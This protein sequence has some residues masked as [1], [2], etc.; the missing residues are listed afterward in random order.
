MSAMSTRVVMFSIVAALAGCSPRS[1]PPPPATAARASELP[2]GAVIPD[3]PVVLQDGFKL[4]LR[5]LK[6]KVIALYFCSAVADP[7]CVRESQALGERYRE[8]HDEHHVAIVG[9]TRENAALHRSFIAQHALP[10]DLAS[11][12]NAEVARAYGVPSQGSYAPQLFL[13]NRDNTL[14]ARWSAADPEAQLRE[15][16]AAAGG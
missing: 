9:V 14:R 10:F 11:D 6:G 15:I 5:A 7:E 4:D 3:V 12:P 8:L 16:L 13:I 1:E 2:V